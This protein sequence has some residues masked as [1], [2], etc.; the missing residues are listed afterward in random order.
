MDSLFFDITITLSVS[1]LSPDPDD[2]ITLKLTG[3]SPTITKDL[4]EG[5]ISAKADDD[6]EVKSVTLLGGGTA[7]A[8]VSGFIGKGILSENRYFFHYIY[9]CHEA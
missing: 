7:I 6:V 1:D 3:L 2:V 8:S 5:Y 4:I 9:P